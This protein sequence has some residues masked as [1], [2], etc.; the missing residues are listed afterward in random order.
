[1]YVQGGVVRTEARVALEV[2]TTGF[3]ASITRNKRRVTLQ[4]A[5]QTSLSNKTSMCIHNMHVVKIAF[6]EN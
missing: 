5:V 6:P 2:V 1:M 3:V 4:K